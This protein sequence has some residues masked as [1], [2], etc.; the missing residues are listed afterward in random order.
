MDSTALAL[1]MD[2]G[3]PIVVFDMNVAGNICRVIRGEAIGT[4]VT[5]AA[6]EEVRLA[7]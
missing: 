3:L 5:N 2:N 6:R 1:C 7:T 4:L